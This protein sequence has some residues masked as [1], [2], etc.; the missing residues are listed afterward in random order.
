MHAVMIGDREADIYEVFVAAQTASY[1]VLVRSARNRR[2]ADP[3]GYLWAAVEA[4]DILG[5][6]EIDVP[7]RKRSSPCARLR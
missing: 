7:H 5:T 6:V 1:D 4:T 2:P 3:E